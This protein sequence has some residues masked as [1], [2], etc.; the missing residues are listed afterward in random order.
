MKSRI[1]VV[2]SLSLLVVFSILL[3]SPALAVFTNWATI[4]RGDNWNPIY[5][6]NGE[7]SL[8]DYQDIS[9]DG[10]VNGF[11]TWASASVG[12]DGTTTGNV[13]FRILLNNN[14][15]SQNSQGVWKV[16][17][18]SGVAVFLDTSDALAPTSGTVQNWCIQ[19]SKSGIPGELELFNGP[20]ASANNPLNQVLGTITENGTG[21]AGTTWTDSTGYITVTDTGVPNQTTGADIFTVDITVPF[22]WFAAGSPYLGANAPITMTTPVRAFYGTSTEPNTINKDYFI[23]PASGQSALDFTETAIFTFGNPGVC[24]F[25]DDTRDANPPS[26]GGTWHGGDT[27]TVNAYGFPWNKV[28][29]MQVYDPTG[30]TL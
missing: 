11:G 8:K 27:L 12:S 21:G 10:P 25:A 22:A 26:S 15:L 2:I 20:S 14:P 3:P 16:N 18:N 30:K 19:L 17:N 29:T 4:N 1:L 28:L 24:G 6:D 5:D 13:Y 9:S 23:D 7:N